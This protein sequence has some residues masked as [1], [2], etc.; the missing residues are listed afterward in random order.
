VGGCSRL[1][2]CPSMREDLRACTRSIYLIVEQQTRQQNHGPE[3]NELV[4]CT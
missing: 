4:L 3:S 1:R 2:S